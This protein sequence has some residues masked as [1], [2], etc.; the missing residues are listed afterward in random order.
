MYSDRVLR[1][2]MLDG[3]SYCFAGH[4]SPGIKGISDLGGGLRRP[5]GQPAADL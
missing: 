5:G 2:C 3:H 4:L 1:D